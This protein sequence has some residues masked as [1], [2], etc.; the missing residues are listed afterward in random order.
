ME[1]LIAKLTTTFP[2]ISANAGAREEASSVQAGVFVVH[3]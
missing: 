1:P 2:G 3:P